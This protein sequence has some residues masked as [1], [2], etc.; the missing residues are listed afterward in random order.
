M[1]NLKQTN[2]FRSHDPTKRMAL[3][4]KICGDKTC[5]LEYRLMEN[6]LI[7][8]DESETLKCDFP[9]S[10]DHCLT[11]HHFWVKCPVWSCELTPSTL[12]P[13]PTPSPDS[14]P[15]FCSGPGCIASFSINALILLVLVIL[16]VAYRVRKR[17]QRREQVLFD[18][19]LFGTDFEPFVNESSTL[20][21]SQSEGRVATERLPLLPLANP[22]RPP[23][24]TTDSDF[25]SVD[26]DPSP[27]VVV[28]PA[29]MSQSAPLLSP[30][31]E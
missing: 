13:N 25:V 23:N 12:S 2:S 15:S 27:S 4:D 8:F 20:T 3:T 19:A 6:C 9:C 28:K 21:R 18:N 22:S 16:V 24:N 26:L 31:S 17:R 1:L 10:K 11:E 5:V 30:I 29:R 14:G 7:Y